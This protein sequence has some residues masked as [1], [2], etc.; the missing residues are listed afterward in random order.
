MNYKPYKHL[1]PFK[2]MVLQNFPFIEEDFDAITNYQLLCKIVEYLRNVI[3]N[4]LTMEENITNLYNEFV[5]LK[6]YIDNYFTNLDVQEEIN[7]KLD[8][9]ASDGSLTNLIKNYVDP[10]YQEYE[11]N[12]NDAINI[13]NGK[14]EIIENQVN[15]LASG[16]PIPVSSTSDMTDTNKIYVNTTDGYWYYYNKTNWVQGGVYQATGI[17]PNTINA[18]MIK[19]HKRTN[20]LF[21]NFTPTIVKMIYST[22]TLKM[23]ENANSTTIVIP[24]EPNTK[25]AF[26]KTLG[27]RFN[28]WGTKNFPDVGEDVLNP[29]RD[30]N[31]SSPQ[32][33]IYET[34]SNTNY[35]CFWVHNTGAEPN[36]N[37]QDLL[38][39]VM[40]NKG[41]T[42]LPYEP[43]YYINIKDEDLTDNNI[44]L[45][46]LKV[47]PI[48]EK[49]TSNIKKTSQLV[50][51]DTTEIVHLIPSNETEP[52][53]ISS[54]QSYTIV[55]PC[56]PNTS[57]A[58][59]KLGGGV[60]FCV[61]GTK[62]YPYV[63]NKPLNMYNSAWTSEANLKRCIYTTDAESNYLC[64]FF[65]NS[66]AEPSLN[67]D[68][69]IRNIMINKGSRYNELTTY[70]EIENNNSNDFIDLGMFKNIGFV[71]D[72]YTQ[73]SFYMH[74][75]W[76]D[77]KSL[78]ISYPDYIGKRNGNNILNCG[79][80]GSTTRSWISSVNG[81][82]RI[83]NNPAQDLYFLGL[84]INDANQLGTNYLGT[85]ND[86]HDDY[87]LNPD[88]FYGNYGKII[89]QIKQHAPYCKFI[90][91]GCMRPK[92]MNINYE[93]FTNAIS[94][95]ANHYDI[96]FINPYDDNF[97]Y[98]NC[99]NTLSNFHPTPAGY[100]GISKAIERLSSKVINENANYFLD[101]NYANL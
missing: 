10:I 63:G 84:G 65:Y 36:I 11:N 49:S 55:I 95:I 83:L 101:S 18:E 48:T 75:T 71:G 1:P 3:A 39:T 73:G 29:L 98:S 54:P 52:I 30:F 68:D 66:N 60:R 21:N 13:Q 15:S 35:L 4:E 58:I 92:T 20:N 24:C 6:N 5:S 59:Q 61:W 19:F 12:I 97:F 25:Y 69:M 85:I 31:M 80:G 34:T 78:G 53:L 86:I 90:M 81:L 62:T 57:Y 46:K 100:N 70:Y 50:N 7:N 45:N 87:N 37:I 93:I 76:Y 23:I 8:E 28:I 44:D 79:V 91:I 67:F 88:T 16:A 99:M 82:Q 26:K 43:Y 96:P 74:D 51:I 72:S 2:G 22:S 27:S 64:F 77:G 32:Y 42:Y 94:E 40:I 9:M 33:D 47:L 38:N 56:E 89:D 41:D 17:A 14:I